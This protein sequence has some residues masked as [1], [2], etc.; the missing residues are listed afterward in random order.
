LSHQGL[1]CSVESSHVHS[2]VRSL[3]KPKCLLAA[4]PVL[5]ERTE[6]DWRLNGE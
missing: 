3:T 1:Q 5:I 6:S 2:Y 4:L